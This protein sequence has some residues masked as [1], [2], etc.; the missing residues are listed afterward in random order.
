MRFPMRQLDHDA[1]GV[2]RA[3]MHERPLHEPPSETALSTRLAYVKVAQEPDPPAVPRRPERIELNE[4]FG[5][6]SAARQEDDRVFTSE[7]FRQEPFRSRSIV[8][9]GEKGAIRIEERNEI[10]KIFGA[11]SSDDN[12]GDNLRASPSGNLNPPLMKN[13]GSTKRR[14]SDWTHESR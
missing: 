9:P 7:P 4:A 12:V 13:S 11:G 1:R 8:R 3:R 2:R 14:R 6:L 5:Q 10:R